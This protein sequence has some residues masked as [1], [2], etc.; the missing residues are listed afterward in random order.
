MEELK[1]F[2]IKVDKDPSYFTKSYDDIIKLTKTI[3]FND[4]FVSWLADMDNGGNSYIR[5]IL[6]YVYIHG[7]GIKKQP[8]KVF[9]LC[10]KAVEQNNSYAQNMM[11]FLYDDGIAVK[12]DVTKAIEWYSK[13]ADQG[14]PVAQ[15]NMSLIYLGGINCEKDY[16]KAYEYAKKSADQGDHGAFSI[17]GSLYEKGLY[18]EKDTDMAIDYYIKSSN[19]NNEHSIYNLAKLYSHL[20][21]YVNSMKWYIAL[22]Q[23]HKD[24]SIIGIRRLTL[25][26]SNTISMFKSMV[27]EINKLKAENDILKKKLEEEPVVYI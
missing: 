13:S 5:L 8:E 14:N 21:D 11:G 15:Y 9:E 20:G 10:K 6:C 12:K 22:L 1:E 26:P 23:Y 3:E 19:R 25:N 2:I 4:S 17:L 7:K 27:D 16:K 18:V 24:D